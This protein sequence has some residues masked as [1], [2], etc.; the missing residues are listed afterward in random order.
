LILYGFESKIQ[1]TSTQIWQHNDLIV[2]LRYINESIMGLTK[3]ENYTEEQVNLGKVLKVMGHPARI[4]ILQS[5]I[6]S[7]TCICGELVTEIGLAQA[8]ISQHLKELKSVGLI[9]GTIDGTSVCYCINLDT[10]NSVKSSLGDLFDSVKDKN[11]C[12]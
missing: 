11:K 8:T 10:W 7:Q 4:A 9:Q 1:K 6:R 5:I 12:C 3:T 2:I